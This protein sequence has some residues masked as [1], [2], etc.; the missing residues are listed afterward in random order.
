[1]KV[2]TRFAPS[3]TG[4]VH[5]GNIRVANTVALGALAVLGSVCRWESLEAAVAATA[6]AAFRQLN[7]DAAAR[8][9]A[10]AAEVAPASA[11]SA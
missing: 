6:P 8:G 7:L 4:K 1:M 9:R 5:I 11:A 3:P 2:R 10:M